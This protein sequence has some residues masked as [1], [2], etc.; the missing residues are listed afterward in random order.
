MEFLQKND[1]E[2]NIINARFLKF[3]ADEKIINFINNSK[4]VV[5]IEDGISVGGL[6]SNVQ[7][8]IMSN[9][10]DHVNFKNF[11]YPK[12]FIEHGTTEQLEQK[13]GLDKDSIAKKIE[14]WIM[15]KATFNL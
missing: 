9:N 5:T 11:G 8:F 10:F 7:D 6:G 4:N 2:S 3:K 12:K 14:D 13:Y 1:I 15:Q